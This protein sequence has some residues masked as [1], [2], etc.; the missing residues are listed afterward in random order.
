MPCEMENLT[1]TTQ[2]HRR[3]NALQHDHQQQRTFQLLPWHIL[4]LKN[5]I[6]FHFLFVHTFFVLFASA[7]LGHAPF[8]SALRIAFLILLLSAAAAS[9]ARSRLCGFPRAMC[10]R[11]C[12]LTCANDAGLE[13]FN[14][15]H[16]GVL[17]LLW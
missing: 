1:K 3:N 14:F 7:P 13:P 2:S 5:L 10:R 17:L 16:W 6:A 4:K 9:Y 12:L 8:F 15:H 11:I